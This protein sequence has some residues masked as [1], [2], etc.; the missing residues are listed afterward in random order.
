VRGLAR[1]DK[2]EG[3]L[4]LRGL[5]V[6]RDGPALRF[7]GSSPRALGEGPFEHGLPIPG[8]VTVAETG[9][10]VRASV[11]R[12]EAVRT[13]TGQPVTVA[14]L[15]ADAVAAPLTVRNRR[16][17]DRFHPLGAPGSRKLQD[18]FVD[19]KIPRDARDRVPL[20]VDAN[21]RIVWVV[22]VAIAE[23]CRVTTP[24]SGVVILELKKGN[25]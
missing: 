9:A 19:H 4:D 14:V 11:N 2:S 16:R 5:Q 18:V 13:R 3:H 15:S 21:G 7:G 23:Q 1:A 22:G 25:Q 24:D 6:E 17:G 10:I 12:G 20:V 8:Q